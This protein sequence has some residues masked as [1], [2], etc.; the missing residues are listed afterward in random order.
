M[1][2]YANIEKVCSDM[3]TFLDAMTR[4]L[5]IHFQCRYNYTIFYVIM[6]PKYNEFD[7]LAVS[8]EMLKKPATVYACIQFIRFHNN[9]LLI[10]L[11][12]I[13]IVFQE[14]W[15]MLPVYEI[16][17]RNHPKFIKLLPLLS[18]MYFAD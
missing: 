6:I 9:K 15:P 17:L 11:Q 1:S 16:R 3:C 4:H 12:Y 10:C 13:F 8:N 18:C 5:A 7:E 2:Q 14:S